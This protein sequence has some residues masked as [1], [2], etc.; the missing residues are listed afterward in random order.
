MVNYYPFSRVYSLVPQDLVSKHV[1]CICS[2]DAKPLLAL[3]YQIATAKWSKVITAMV[4]STWRTVGGIEAMIDGPG[5][6]QG[7]F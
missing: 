7:N 4:L 5:C 1:C 6:Q 2:V 3:S